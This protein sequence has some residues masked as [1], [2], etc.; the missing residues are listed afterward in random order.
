[1]VQGF[2]AAAYDAISRSS[3]PVFG[4]LNVPIL[5]VALD[6]NCCECKQK[7]PRLKYDRFTM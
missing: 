6:A 7:F 2:S 4:E 5:I 3:V 1:M